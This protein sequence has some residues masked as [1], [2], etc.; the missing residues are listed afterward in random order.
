M[1]STLSYEFSLLKQKILCP[2]LLNRPSVIKCL[3]SWDSVWNR[4]DGAGAD[5]WGHNDFT[6]E[7]RQTRSAMLPLWEIHTQYNNTHTLNVHMFFCVNIIVL[8]Y[9]P[10]WK[11]R[12]RNAILKYGFPFLVF[13]CSFLN[14]QFEWY[15]PTGKLKLF[16][17]GKEDDSY[18]E[19]F[20]SIS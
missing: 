10:I 14:C 19:F 5:Q 7:T 11:P 15:L 16:K 20:K 17:R 9:V 3:I 12:K 1:T 4:L 18:E 8:I 13:M 6:S 2:S